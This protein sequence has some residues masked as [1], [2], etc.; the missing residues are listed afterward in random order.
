[1]SR[2]DLFVF[3]NAKTGQDEEFNR[4]YDG[5]HLPELMSLDG[6]SGGERYDVG[7]GLDGQPPKFNYL[8]VYHLEG[9]DPSVATGQLLNAAR[10]G[11][12][13]PS[14]AIDRTET[15]SFVVKRR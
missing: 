7:P 10:T 8:A 1:M 11:K 9:D 2:Y 14:D 15:L 5:T 13:T 3:T 6:I 12:L 4:W